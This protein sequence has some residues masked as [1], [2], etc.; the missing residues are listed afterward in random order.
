M[1][2]K[3]FNTVIPWLTRLPIAQIHTMQ[4]NIPG[5]VFEVFWVFNKLMQF[6]YS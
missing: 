4:K 2:F 1:G 3:K 6:Q 5:W